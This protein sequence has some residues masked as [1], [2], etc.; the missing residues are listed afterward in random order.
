VFLLIKI[1]MKFELNK[2]ELE[3]VKKFKESFRNIFGH[4]VELEYIFGGGEG[5]GRTLKIRCQEINIEKDITDYE[6]W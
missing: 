4:D 5:I 2:K 6:S 3:E 1:N